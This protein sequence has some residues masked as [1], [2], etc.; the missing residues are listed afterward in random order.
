LAGITYKELD[1]SD[2]KLVRSG[3]VAASPRKKV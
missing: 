2:D 3:Q 1:L